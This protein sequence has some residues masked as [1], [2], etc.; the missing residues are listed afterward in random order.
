MRLEAVED[1]QVCTALMAN[2]MHLVNDAVKV[3]F[4]LYLVKL[5][6]E[7]QACSFSEVWSDNRSAVL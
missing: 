4:F 3:A 2:L 6:R 5:D 7:F 1:R